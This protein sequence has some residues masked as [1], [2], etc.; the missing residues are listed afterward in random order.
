MLATRIGQGFAGA[1]V[2][3]PG[4][5]LAGD[6]AS[7][8]DAGSKLYSLTMSFGPG[9]ALAPLVAGYLVRFGFLTPFALGAG[10]ALVGFVL[11][12]AQVPEPDRSP[13]PTERDAPGSDA[14]APSD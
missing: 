7:D 9:T 4:L 3:A 1:L 12:H 5:A 8:R 10:L 13:S 11:V 2:F 14:T 6:R